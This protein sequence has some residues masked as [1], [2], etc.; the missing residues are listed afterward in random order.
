MRPAIVGLCV[1]SML[2]AQSE[3]SLLGRLMSGDDQAAIPLPGAKVLLEES[4]SQ[5]IT[6]ENGHFRLFL[7][8]ELRP[9]DEITITVTAFG[10]AIYD[11][12]GGKLRVPSDLKRTRSVIRLLPKGSLKFLSDTQLKAFV[13]RSAKDASHQVYQTGDKD[14]P[15]PDAP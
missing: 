2:N 6:N 12:P 15:D 13:E 5:G 8:D 10:L 9:G 4:G 11:P 7:P 14:V 1:A 3:R